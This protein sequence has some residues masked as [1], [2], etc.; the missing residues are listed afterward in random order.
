MY[1]AW[2]RLGVL[3]YI[4]Y[5]F[6]CPLQAYGIV[7]FNFKVVVGIYKHVYK[8]CVVE[9]MKRPRTANFSLNNNMP[10]AHVQNISS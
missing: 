5:I 4:S 7:F 3:P 2:Q 8:S 10:S 9:L 1:L 6:E